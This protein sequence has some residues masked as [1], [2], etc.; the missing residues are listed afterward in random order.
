MLI[1]AATLF[2]AAP[3]VQSPTQVYSTSLGIAEYFGT[4]IAVSGDTLASGT[5]TAN[6][7]YVFEHVGGAWSETA[8]VVPPP[9]FGGYNFGQAVALDGDTLVVGAPGQFALPG[10]AFVYRRSGTT[11]SLEAPLVLTSSTINTGYGQT[12]A[13]LGDTA[14]VAAPNEGDGAVYVFD[15]SGTSWSVGARLDPTL[16][17]T[18]RRYG[19]SLAMDGSTLLVGAPYYNDYYPVHVFVRSGSTWSQQ[20]LLDPPLGAPLDFGKGIALCG[21]EAVV[22][23]AGNGSEAGAAY[24]FRRTGSSWAMVQTLVPSGSQPGDD[25]GASAALSADLLAVGAPAPDA[26]FLDTEAVYA[27]RESGAVWT[28]EST[29]PGQDPQ[30]MEKIGASLAIHGQTVVA[31]APTSGLGPYFFQGT[32]MEYISSLGGLIA[33]DTGRRLAL[34]GPL[35]N[36][37]SLGILNS[38]LSFSGFA[39]DPVSGFLW[40]SSHGSDELWR[41]DT[42]TWT[43]TF[44][45]AL[46]LPG[47]R[48]LAHTPYGLYGLDNSTN[49]LVTVNTVTAECTP[50]GGTLGFNKSRGLA[51]DPNTETLYGCSR[52]NLYRINR[53]TGAGVHVLGL[54]AAA[55]LSL[56]FDPVADRLYALRNDDSLSEIDPV[57]L[58][59]TPMDP[60]HLINSGSAYVF[61]LGSLET[62]CTAGTSASGCVAAISGAGSA[63]ASASSG[64]DLIAADV[65][66]KKRGLFF[67]GTN[68]RQAAPW[69]N[70]SSYQ[71][72]I[73]PVTR[74]NLLQETGTSGLCDGYHTLDLNAWFQAKPSTNPGAGNLVQTQFWYRDPFGGSNV[75]TSL[76]DALEFPLGP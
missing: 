28:E 69:G 31:G 16:A 65:E 47:M 66:G 6:A 48:G 5:P 23:A 34:V 24:V 4:S 27:F 68:G 12:V 9:G 18:G 36:S 54:G 75:G 13:L 1:L 26:S 38:P 41:I 3:A 30:D 44:V 58:S 40:A 35:P 25:F 72:V 51:W 45:G 46:D 52:F 8:K 39:H 43:A 7:V 56:T 2:A 10:E 57:A 19:A 14:V 11:W 21:D 50:V 62:Y 32:S 63:S 71:C 29:L 33:I 70:G 37:T 17:P 20:E 22:G 76:S 67:Y 61:D 60:V 15:R 55:C 59:V 64:F 73:P 53:T 42:A 74:T 49:Q